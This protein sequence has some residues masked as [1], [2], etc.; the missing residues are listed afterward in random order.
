MKLREINIVV[1]PSPIKDYSAV[2]MKIL[3]NGKELELHEL[4]E[5]NDFKSRFEQI[6]DLVKKEVIKVVDE[7]D[8][9]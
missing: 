9:Y 3:I 8:N 4:L 2:D 7:E 6:L 1:K 5:I